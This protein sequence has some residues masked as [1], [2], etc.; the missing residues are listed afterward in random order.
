MPVFAAEELAT[1]GIDGD[2][3]TGEGEKRGGGEA[4]LLVV[5]SWL[6]LAAT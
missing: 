5:L 1:G 2:F 6:A 4:A 3:R